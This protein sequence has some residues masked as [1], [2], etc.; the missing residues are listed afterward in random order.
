MLLLSSRPP[1][2]TGMLLFEIA[3]SY[4]GRASESFSTCDSWLQLPVW[5]N[6]GT[7]YDACNPYPRG[8]RWRHLLAVLS[9]M[10]ESHVRIAC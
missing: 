2:E 5:L 3:F 7:F 8:W 4:L 6:I 10:T 1:K 9:E